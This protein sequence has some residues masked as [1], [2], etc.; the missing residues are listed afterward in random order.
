MQI[1]DKFINSSSPEPSPSAESPEDCQLDLLQ[2]FAQQD[3]S[4]ASDCIAGEEFYQQLK[5]VPDAII[6]LQY[7]FDQFLS[8]HVS[9]VQQGYIMGAGTEAI[10]LRCQIDGK[11]YTF[12]REHLEQMS[13]NERH[14]LF[15]QLELDS[16]QFFQ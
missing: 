7:K 12:Y 8:F 3:H 9:Q 1:N 2:V 15:K 10:C 16:S 5:S 14:Q 13:E 11:I 4:D 6:S